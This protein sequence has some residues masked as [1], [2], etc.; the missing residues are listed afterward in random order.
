MNSRSSLLRHRLLILCN[1]VV[2]IC[3]LGAVFCYACYRRD[4]AS[5]REIARIQTADSS[6]AP[7]R[8]LTLLHWVY[9]NHGFH[10]NAEYFLVPRWRATPMQIVNAGGDCADKSRL[11]WALLDELSIRSSMVMCFDPS[12]Q[13]PVHT[14]VEAQV[15]RD[16]YM[17]ADPVYDMCFPRPDGSG[18]YGLLE[19]RADSQILGDRLWILRA[20]FNHRHPV[21]AYREERAVYTHASSM[22]WTRNK[23]SRCLGSIFRGVVGDA[24]Y[25][26]RRPAVLEEPQLAC[27]ASFGGLAAFFLLSGRLVKHIARHAQGTTRV[28]S[29]IHL[30]PQPTC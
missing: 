24:M 13:Y 20:T 30:V 22:N 16:E 6:T 2:F 21:H 29:P 26:W 19:M 27:A 8:V 25:R 28:V 1:S 15:G 18:Y 3:A 4:R 17:V 5:I 23:A 12:G 11:L 9:H 14:V 7:E 10:E